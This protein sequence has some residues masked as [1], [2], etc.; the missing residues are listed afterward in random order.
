MFFPS[1]IAV[2]LY[3]NTQQF[4]GR[5]AGGDEEGV[6][7]RWPEDLIIAFTTLARLVCCRVTCTS[8]ENQRLW[9][10]AVV[11]ST[12][13]MDCLVQVGDAFLTQV[14]ELKWVREWWSVRLIGESKYQPLW[15]RW[16]WARRQS[17]QFTGQALVLPFLGRWSCS[18]NWEEKGLACK[19]LG[20]PQP[21]SLCGQGK[22]S[23]G[24]FA[25]VAAPHDLILDKWKMM[26]DGWMD[27]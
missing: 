1:V 5:V 17:S 6:T 14:K 9:S 19:H 3:S 25:W 26:M 21:L 24:Q 27:V 18:S 23:L 4:V 13:Q 12:N 10:E 16:S 20:T 8:D 7:G 2:G 22:G 15:L 11:L